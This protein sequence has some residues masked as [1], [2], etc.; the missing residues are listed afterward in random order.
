MPPLWFQRQLMIELRKYDAVNAERLDSRS[1]SSH[2]QSSAPLHCSYI[3]ALV[4]WIPPRFLH[5][6]VVFFFFVVFYWSSGPSS[7]CI[8]TRSD[9]RKW[10]LFIVNAFFFLYFFPFLFGFG[11]GRGG[12]GGGGW[13]A[14]VVVLW[15]RCWSQTVVCLFFPVGPLI[16]WKSKVFVVS[17]FRMCRWRVYALEFSF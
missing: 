9:D 10:K 13:G 3:F 17:L 16:D 8:K 12:G 6:P 15:A 14:W 11:P 2:V 7:G 4:S 5:S 1:P